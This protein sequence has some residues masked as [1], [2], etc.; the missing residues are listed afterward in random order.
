M[1]ELI[2]RCREERAAYLTEG[3]LRSPAC[4][5][6][7]RRAFAGNQ[8]AWSAIDELL[9]PLLR[10]WARVSGDVAV[11]RVTEPDDVIQAAYESFYRSAPK[12]ANELLAT[13][14]LGPVLA[15]LQTTVKRTGI[16]MIRDKRARAFHTSLDR[17]TQPTQAQATKE[18]NISDLITLVSLDE[19]TNLAAPTQVED[20]I[21]RRLFATTLLEKVAKTTQDRMVFQWYLVNGMT[22]AEILATYPDYFVNDK[23]LRQIIQTLVRRCRK[24]LKTLLANKQ[25]EY[26]FRHCFIQRMDPAQLVALFPDQFQ[27]VAQVRNIIKALRER[28]RRF[29]SDDMEDEGSSP[30]T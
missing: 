18:S 13:D 29:L 2:Q 3:D 16:R 24:L 1:D 8:D 26:V 28:F 20:E 9:K 23:Q 22:P 5:E 14:S 21:S 4:V 6:L 19:I 12:R 27:H 10:Q 30:K 7:F 15:Y 25:E 17:S 11:A